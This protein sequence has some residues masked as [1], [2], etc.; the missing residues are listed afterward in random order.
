MEKSLFVIDAKVGETVEHK[1][2]TDGIELIQMYNDGFIVGEK[3][4]N[5]GIYY[6][7]PN[8]VHIQEDNKVILLL[9]KKVPANTGPLINAPLYNVLK[10]SVA[11]TASPSNALIF[12]NKYRLSDYTR[13]RHSEIVHNKIA[14]PNEDTILLSEHEIIIAQLNNKYKDVLIELTKKTKALEKSESD[15]NV[16][17]SQ[18][19]IIRSDKEM[20]S[21]KHS[22][23]IDMMR[24][25]MSKKDC[26]IEELKQKLSVYQVKEKEHNERIQRARENFKKNWTDKGRQHKIHG[27]K[28]EEIIISLRKK[29][30]KIKEIAEILRRSPTTIEKILEMNG[31]TKKRMDNP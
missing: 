18:L 5:V 10:G 12:F 9:S 3:M 13:R 6:F 7:P 14:T 4:G 1:T 15:N 27:Y 30:M 11:L 8:L 22:S 21:K 23:D 24:I 29:G 31:M 17:K 25:N 26:E 20:A 28:E 19:E 2:I 16:L